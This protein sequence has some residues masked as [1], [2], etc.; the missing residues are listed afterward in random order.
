MMEMHL[1][2]SP[3]T[4]VGYNAPG[5][6]DTN[7]AV[8]IA[9][10]PEE[11]FNKKFNTLPTPYHKM[12]LKMKSR[13]VDTKKINSAASLPV[14]VNTTSQMEEH[15]SM[16]QGEE[17]ELDTTVPGMVTVPFLLFYHPKC[18][19]TKW[20]CPCSSLSDS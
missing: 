1:E 3:E 6:E 10:R 5:F 14:V 2:Y 11:I 7:Q 18:L 17:E 20:R 16:E 12:Q 13:L 4:P 19:E 15:S 8:R 9:G